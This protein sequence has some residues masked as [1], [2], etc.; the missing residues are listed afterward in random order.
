MQYIGDIL[1]I[2]INSDINN[3]LVLVGQNGAGKTHQLNV[4]LENIENGIMI[5]EDGMPQ[6]SRAINKVNIDEVNMVYLYKNEEKRGT[7]TNQDEQ[8]RI[9]ESAEQIVK[10]CLK[11]VNQLSKILNKSK[12]QE[13][14]R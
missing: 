1:M 6:F 8:V 9:S 4:A 11:I 13:K 12:G 10:Y 2:D 3:L 7:Y 14:T 5:T